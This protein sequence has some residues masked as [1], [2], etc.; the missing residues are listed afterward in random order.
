M[1]DRKPKI[2]I[3]DSEKDLA[4]GAALVFSEIAF[5]CAAAQGRFAVALSGGAT[6]RAMYRLLA[7]EEHRTYIPWNSIHLFWV[8]ERLVP[9][10]D[11]E[12]NYGG[13]RKELLRHLSLPEGQIHPIPVDIPAADGALQYEQSIRRFFRTEEGKAPVF[14]L[15]VL[16][17]GEDG[18]TASLFPAHPALEEKEKLVLAVRGGMPDVDR[19][20]MTLPLIN[21]ASRIIVLASGKRKARIVARIVSGDP[22]YRPAPIRRIEPVNGKV[23]WMMDRNAASEL[24][25]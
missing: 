25:Q 19:I 2:L 18:H 10:G 6:P 20:T 3:Y 21:Q 4:M 23:L 11:R 5:D 22:A 9:R 7:G 12:S 13:I 15:I 16:G 8:D 1:M 14:D 17:L 24:A